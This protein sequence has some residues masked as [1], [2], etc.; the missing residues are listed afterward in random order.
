MVTKLSLA[1]VLS[2]GIGTCG[3]LTQP[4]PVGVPR[5]PGAR[6]IEPLPNFREEFKAAERCSGVRK[7][8]EPIIW[9]L[10][11]G[12]SF[13]D[14]K[15]LDEWLIGYWVKPDTIYIG[16]Q[17]VRSWVPRHEVLHY[18]HQNGEHPVEVFGQAC[19]AMQGYL[20]SDDPNYRP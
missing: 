6:R 8:F 16:E 17:W 20:M 10:V 2:L 7:K 4:T 3:T 14:P 19:H 13:R 18:L 15:D 11:P 12:Q 9:Y 1:L 5:I